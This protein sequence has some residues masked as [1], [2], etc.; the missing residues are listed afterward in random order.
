MWIVNVV[1]ILETTVRGPGLVVAWRVSARDASLEL[2][3]LLLLTYVIPFRRDFV[4]PRSEI[5]LYATES[6]S[7][8]WLGSSI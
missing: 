3:S 2:K 8:R 4:A 5:S 7:N 6:G 1:F